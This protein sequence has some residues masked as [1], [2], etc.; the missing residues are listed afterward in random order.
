VLPSVAATRYVTPL[1]EGGSLPGLMEADDLG[2]YVVKFIGAGQGRKALIADVI[3]GALARALGLPVPALVTVEVDPVLAANEPDEEVQDLLRASAGRN[4]GVDYLP[5]ALDLDPNAFD[6][7]P[8]FAGRVLWFDAF[9]A[10]VDR[11]WRNPNMLFWHGAPYLIDHGA[12]LT[13]HHNWPTAE[14]AASRP[15]DATDHVLIGS[16][17][18]LVAAE[19]F[20]LTDGVIADAIDQVPAEWLT[21]EPGFGTAADVRAAYARFF[22]ARLAA[23][24][25]WLPPLY[26]AVAAGP[27]ARSA[28]RGGRSR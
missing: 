26:A 19:D 8:A 12:A 27:S 20:D 5:G 3:V 14:Q 17:P 28:G 11:T 13:F 6:V 1:R 24:E 25:S 4:L 16:A 21:D 23:R 9:V 22:A 7:D 2:T 15:Y 18:E 10:N